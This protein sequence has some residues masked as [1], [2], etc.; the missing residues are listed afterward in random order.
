MQISQKTVMLKRSAVGCVGVAMGVESQYGQIPPCVLQLINQPLL[1]AFQQGTCCSFVDVLGV[2][3]LANHHPDRPFPSEQS[4][5]S[6]HQLSN[7]SWL[8]LTQANSKPQ[9]ETSGKKH[10]FQPVG[11]FRLQHLGD[12]NVL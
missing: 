4:A 2:S 8:Q 6:L 7:L 10:R 12:A 11:L 5:A 1:L 9:V 3:T